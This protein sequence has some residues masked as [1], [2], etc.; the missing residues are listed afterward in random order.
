[1]ALTKKVS[2]GGATLTIAITGR[3]D[4]TLHKEFREAYTEANKGGAVNSY[5]IDLSGT[6]YMD[7]SALG[8][9]LLLRE[10]A[11]GDKGNIQ[12]KNCNSEIK[13]I[14]EISNFDRLFNIA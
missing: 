7:S 1:M 14:L 11:G 10:F 3:F 8:M 9:L 6:D 13:E 5:I 4:F 2:D 12:I